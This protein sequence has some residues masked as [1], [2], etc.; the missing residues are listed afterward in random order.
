[1]TTLA[2]LSLLLCV[3]VAGVLWPRSLRQSHSVSHRRGLHVFRVA[4]AAGEVAFWWNTDAAPA[5]AQTRT[6]SRH[7]EFDFGA[8][9]PGIVGKPSRELR[10]RVPGVVAYDAYDHLYAYAIA[11]GQAV[12]RK[13]VVAVPHWLAALPLAAF[14]AAV[15]VRRRRARRKMLASCACAGCG[16]DLRA[17]PDRCP[18]CGRASV[19][20]VS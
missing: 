20:P 7:G 13:R 9:I 15:L 11:G 4:S 12:T 3:T 10:G 16:Y 5:V 1:V 2:A 17:T 18:E 6:P 19:P 14:P 8:G